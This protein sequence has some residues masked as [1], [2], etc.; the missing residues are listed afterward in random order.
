MKKEE[1]LKKLNAIQNKAV[2]ITIKHLK[3]NNSALIVMATGMG[4]TE[5]AIKLIKCLEK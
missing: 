3:S 1:V 4:K 2:N 5:M